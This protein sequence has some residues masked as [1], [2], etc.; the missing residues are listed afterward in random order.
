MAY[1]FPSGKGRFAIQFTNN[2]GERPTI[3]L[4]KCDRKHAEDVARKIEHILACQLHN[5]S[6]D[7]E[8]AVWLNQL[9]PALRTK[10]A[11]AGLVDDVPPTTI[12]D[13]CD[14]CAKHFGGKRG[15]QTNY[16]HSKE[17]LIAFFGAD[18]A[19]HSITTGDVAEY[20]KWLQAHGYMLGKRKGGPLGLTTASKRAK[21]GKQFFAF[22]VDK[23]WIRENPFDGL[24]GL[25]DSN[26]SRRFYVSQQLI[27]EVLAHTDDPQ[28]RLIVA[29]VRYAGL[30]FPSEVAPLE[31]EWFNFTE[32]CFLVHAPKTEHHPG[33]KYR[34]V[35]MFKRLRP[36]LD[37]AFASLA[38]GSKYL[39]TLVAR[40]QAYTH[41]LHRTI[42]RAGFKVWPKTWHNMR[43]SL[44]T[45][46]DEMGFTIKAITEWCGNSPVVARKHYIQVSKEQFRRAVEGDGL[47]TGQ[48]PSA[49]SD[50]SITSMNVN[51]SQFDL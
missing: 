5:H 17:N 23:H 27:E 34:T 6:V 49:K 18:R 1:V 14:Y 13:L 8:V 16:R 51:E 44:M 25:V 41:R 46:M 39:V 20:W 3:R 36:F 11:K 30:R 12:T 50:A 35:P 21:V 24:K 9:A 10:F 33:K 37:E 38:P 48:K 26:D 31:T 7:V 19:I 15:T 32:E 29:L 40:P 42:K 43:S 4:G 2:S 22:A 47:L 28:L 45:E